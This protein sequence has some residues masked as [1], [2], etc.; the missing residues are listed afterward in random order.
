LPMAKARYFLKKG[1][2]DDSA[3]KMNELQF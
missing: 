1:N 3:A 2:E